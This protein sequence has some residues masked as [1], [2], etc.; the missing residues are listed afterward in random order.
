MVKVNHQRPH[1]E[2]VRPGRTLATSAQL[3]R[4]L[5]WSAMDPTSRCISCSVHFLL[6]LLERPES[7]L[8]GDADALCIL[9]GCQRVS[10][11]IY[12]QRSEGIYANIQ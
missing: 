1:G 12:L 5:P 11:Q 8:L 6:G 10:N 3:M 9:P 4:S 2:P 7:V